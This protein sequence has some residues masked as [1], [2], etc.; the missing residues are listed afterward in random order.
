MH[1]T[2]YSSC[3]GCPTKH[4]VVN[5]KSNHISQNEHLSGNTWVPRR[6]S[7]QVQI[8]YNKD[9]A[10][11][12]IE[13]VCAIISH[14]VHI[15]MAPKKISSR[16]FF[17]K[18]SACPQSSSIFWLN[19]SLSLTTELENPRNTNTLQ[20]HIPLQV[21]QFS[22]ASLNSSPLGFVEL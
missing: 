16:L 22:K 8:N 6:A 5:S 1:Y 12:S 11:A 7:M 20:Q 18:V 13:D 14:C 15:N 17:K 21:N 3:N 10:K 2:M 19:L 4:A 9:L